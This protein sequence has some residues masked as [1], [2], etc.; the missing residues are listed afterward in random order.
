MPVM[1]FPLG[2]LQG[3]GSTAVAASASGHGPRW[4]RQL[5]LLAGAIGWLLFVLAMITHDAGDT[6]FTTSGTGE[7]LRNVIGVLGARVSDL[8]LFLFG[9]SAWWLV[10]VTLRAWLSALAVTLRGQA[11]AEA[12]P[13]DRARTAGLEIAPKLMA[14]TLTSDL[15]TKGV[16]Q[17]PSPITRSGGDR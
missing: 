6:A 16:R 15:P 3:D 5:L 4:R 10:P 14:L 8:A 9:F 11:P 17:Y 7:P 13:R 2:S 1:S 12:A